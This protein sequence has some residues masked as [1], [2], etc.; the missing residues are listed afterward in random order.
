MA[1][2][3]SCGKWK[4]WVEVPWTVHLD[5]Y[6]QPDDKSKKKEQ[7]GGGTAGA[8]AAGITEE[9]KST[10]LEETK[11][12]KDKFDGSGEQKCLK[13][14]KK[15]EDPNCVCAEPINPDHSVPPA[16]MSRWVTTRGYEV[17]SDKYKG[18]F[19]FTLTF[20]HYW[21]GPAGMCKERPDF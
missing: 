3:G 19:S 11:K 12:A 15:T 7:V 2:G 17:H 4:K 14:D 16:P 8:P 9:I 20:E 18:T 21:Q 13:E 10:I 1:C 6:L 5:I